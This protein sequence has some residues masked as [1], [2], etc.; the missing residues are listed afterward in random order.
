[1]SNQY[2][3][4]S[5]DPVRQGYDSSS[6]RTLYGDPAVSGTRLDL[7]NAAILHYG[8]ILRGDAVFSLNIPAP[9]VGDDRKVGF[10]QYN[11][12]AYAYFKIFN[13]VFTAETS[14]GTNTDSVTISWQSAWTDTNTEFR[15]KWEAG[16]ASFYVGGVHQTT[17]N[18]VSVPGDPM[19][20]YLA[21]TSPDGWMLNYIIVKSIQSFWMNENN[22]DALVGPIISEFERITMTESL[23][24]LIPTLFAGTGQ[25][26]VLTL[27]ESVTML[28]IILIAGNGI[29]TET[30]TLTD[31][32]TLA[33]ITTLSIN[34]NDSL[35]T[36]ESVTMDMN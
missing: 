6:W 19:S 28:E 5:Y 25:S 32:P 16:M 4:L 8:D 1:M 23:T 27:T 12:N 21:N 33:L 3:N 18:D 10:V 11:K 14:D 9:T 34:L 7:Q 35:E 17:I 2:F 31:V 24:M 22:E 29:I 20:L 26:D 15:I 13:D 36:T 30:L